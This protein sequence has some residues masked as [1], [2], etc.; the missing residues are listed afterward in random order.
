M[1]RTSV[2]A[3]LAAT[4][5]SA[6]SAGA[7][8]GFPVTVRAANGA[9]T[10]PH[11]P[12]RIVVL[13]ASATETIFA[14][15]AGRQVVAVDDASDHPAQARRKRTRLS[16]FRPSAEAVAR[17]RPDLVITSTKDNKLLPALAKL[18]IP[19]LLAPAPTHVGGA[20]AQMRQ[21]GAATGHR[22]AAD[23]LVNSMRRRIAQ[24]VRRTP[25]GKGITFLH[26]LTPDLYA[27][28][29]PTFIGRIYA[30]FGLANIADK[31]GGD[32]PQLSG[33]YVIAANPQLVVL[34]DTK[35]CGQSAGSVARRPGWDRVAAVENGHV[36]ALDDD[37]PSRWGP[38]IVDFVEL[39]G[40]VVGRMRR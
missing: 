21:I 25:S 33:E 32:Y 4:L 23:R 37:I 27:A 7:D 26:E 9:V 38:R 30:L 5:V 16:T 29:S 36:V 2:V 31:A 15:G 35:C 17:Y 6:S 28:A 8:G 19:T 14:I 12:R 39:V 34:A 40:R 3:A 20:Y 18:R 11:E 10:I 24:V 13:S 1:L 22:P